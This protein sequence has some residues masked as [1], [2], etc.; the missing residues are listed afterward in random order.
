MNSRGEASDHPHPVVILSG[1]GTSR[2]EVHAESKDPYTLPQAEDASGSSP[3]TLGFSR[4]LVAPAPV[5]KL[6]LSNHDLLLVREPHHTAFVM[7]SRGWRVPQ[8]TVL[9]C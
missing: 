8:V 4:L 7:N 9:V 5:M 6:I 3:R 2:S 1:A